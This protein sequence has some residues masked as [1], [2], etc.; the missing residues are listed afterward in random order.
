VT[1][2]GGQPTLVKNTTLARTEPR[3]MCHPFNPSVG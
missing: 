3:T 2:R 1:G